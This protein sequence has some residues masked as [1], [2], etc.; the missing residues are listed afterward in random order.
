MGELLVIAGP[1]ASAFAEGTRLRLGESAVIE[2]GI[3]RTGCPRFESIQGT[4]KQA[5]A[6]RLRVLARVVA[7]GDVAVGD[8][9]TVIS[10]GTPVER[11]EN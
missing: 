5:V 8:A 2:I 1:D 10:A 6:G 11:A 4:T 3:P 7:G 9:V